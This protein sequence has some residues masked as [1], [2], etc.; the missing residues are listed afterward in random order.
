MNPVLNRLLHISQFQGEDL[1]QIIKEIYN[2]TLF[3]KDRDK[4]IRKNNTLKKRRERKENRNRVTGCYHLT[5]GTCH[6][7]IKGNMK[8]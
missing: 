1:L 4:D 3:T 2:C 6:D 7:Y 5:R 8:I